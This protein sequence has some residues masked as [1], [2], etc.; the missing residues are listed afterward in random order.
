MRRRFR[1]Q[2][3]LPADPRPLSPK[4]TRIAWRDCR[5]SEP[6]A[7]RLLQGLAGGRSCSSITTTARYG[8]LRSLLLNEGSRVPLCPLNGHRPS[9]ANPL[10][11][12]DISLGRCDLR[13]SVEKLVFEICRPSP[14]KSR[15]WAAVLV[16]PL[17][18]PL[19]LGLA[20]QVLLDLASRCLGQGTEL[21]Q[22]RS[23]E[24]CEP[25]VAMLDDHDFR[26]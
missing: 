14:C 22:L 18:P 16:N 26:C 3:G 25:R 6:S 12:L 10:G 7:T 19:P 8:L 11:R 9:E 21:H 15:G 5:S 1:W 13:G 24:T 20:Q 2:G 17:L 4:V 23:L